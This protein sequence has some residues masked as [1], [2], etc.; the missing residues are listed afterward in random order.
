M[1]E[2]SFILLIR[3]QALH[4]DPR[5]ALDTF[6]TGL[7]LSYEQG[8]RV[9]VI[10][11]LKQGALA[12]QRAGNS[13]VAAVLLGYVDAQPQRGNEGW[14]GEFHEGVVAEVRAALGDV[15]YDAAAV[16]GAAMPY[17]DIVQYALQE[18]DNALVQTEPNEA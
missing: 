18:T 17:D 11:H 13:E 10:Y 12:L 6:R 14:E 1:V 4:G 15:A 7:R 2:T 16:R 3:L 5:D 8:T 9:N